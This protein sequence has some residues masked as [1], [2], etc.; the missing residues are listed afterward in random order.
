LKTRGER[1]PDRAED[2]DQQHDRE[3]DHDPDQERQSLGDLAREI[4][5]R[6]GLPTD[7]HLDRGAGGGARDRVVAEPVDELRGGLVLGRG[8]A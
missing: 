2:G 5:V 1:D 6:R 3:H 4:L 7:E 8:Q